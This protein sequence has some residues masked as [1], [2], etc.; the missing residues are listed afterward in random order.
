MV[1]MCAVAMLKK[2]KKNA[3][4]AAPATVEADPKGKSKAIAVA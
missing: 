1:L 2:R 4:S 3:A